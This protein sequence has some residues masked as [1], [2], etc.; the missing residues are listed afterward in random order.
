MKYVIWFNEADAQ[1]EALVGGKNASLGRMISD[2]A[3]KVHIPA[4]FAISV[5]GY[6]Y[7]L[8]ANNLIDAITHDVAAIDLSN[9]V[10][11]RQYASAIRTRIENAVWPE[12]MR[13]EILQ[14]YHDLSDFYHQK[15]VAV[16]VR[17]SATTEDLPTASFAGQQ[18]TFLY[19]TG[20]GAVLDAAKK[21][22]ASLFTDRAIFYRAQQH[23]DHMKIGLSVGIQ[24][25]VRSDVGAAGVAFSLDTE[26]GFKDVITIN[27]SWGLGEAVV[28]GEVTPDEYIVS[29]LALK[30]GYASIIK[31]KL[32]SKQTKFI[33]DSQDHQTKFIATTDQERSHFCL[34]DDDI[35]N[36]ARYVSNIE[37]YYTQK[38]NR[39]APQDIEWAKD[40]IDGHIYIVQARPET[41]HT[42]ARKQAFFS[43]YRL[44]Q[45]QHPNIAVTGISIGQKMVQGR[46]RIIRS[47]DEQHLIEQGD[48]LVTQM[49]D[50]DWVTVMKKTA[51]IVTDRG[52][53]TCHAAIVSRELGIPAIVGTGNA[54]D[55]LQDQQEITLD[56]SQGQTGYV[57]AGNVPFT[58]M[59]IDSTKLSRSPVPLLVNMA[60]PDRA[61]S[62]AQLP[63]QG[64]GLARIEFILSELIG[65]HPMAI[66]EPGK[67]SDAV[68]KAISKRSSAYAHPREFFIEKLAQGIGMIAAAWYPHE[69]VVR[70]SDL[71]TN[72]YRQLLGGEYFEPI[73]SNPM[74]GWRGASRFYDDAYQRAFELECHA[75]KKVRQEMGFDNV[76]IM[77]PFVR[78]VQEAE[79][80]ISLMA[81]YG[82]KRGE[83]GLQVLMMIEVPSN[84]LL[85]DRFAR[86]FDG[87]SIGS[88]DLTQL[89]LGIDR[90]S[91][92]L[93]PLF[94]E[95]NDAVKRMIEMAIEGVHAAGRYVGICG[96]GPSDY[97]DFARYL[98]AAHIDSISLNPDAVIPFLMRI[99]Q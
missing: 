58:V 22:M 2:L 92:L 94:D 79:K 73:E 34:T 12:D 47:I 96:Q 16:A 83:H 55:I 91:T 29:K 49:T 31:K 98:I 30:R 24:K 15:Q 52:G 44:Q 95:R 1:K 88:N 50:P 6:R 82:L 97:E 19:I 5:K 3:D 74:I 28:K 81:S 59:Q 54:T 40:G 86:L 67:V 13:S 35:T 70:C 14:A 75:F 84:V 80:V 25:M 89:V 23:F 21:C 56:C 41:I 48:I 77:V 90:D 51:G 11:L 87:F 9:P 43:Q 57:Y 39:L 72:E 33:Y 46:A 45:E 18:E 7:L 64:V 61:F 20:D 4:G 10:T 93:A 65:I 71:K 68:Q 36:I 26:T 8:T 69:V 53:R 17:S 62:I 63:V 42:D 37:N 85:I 60:D 76:R 66:I 27:A 38:Y 32:G 78:T 99:S